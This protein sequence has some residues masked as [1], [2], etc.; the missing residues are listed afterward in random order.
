M[1]NDVCVPEEFECAEDM[2]PFAWIKIAKRL[3]ISPDKELDW[4]GGGVYANAYDIGDGRVIKISSDESD[5][6]LA[7]YL[8][9]KSLFGFVRLYDVFEIDGHRCT[10]SEKMYRVDRHWEKFMKLTDDI[11]DPVKN[12]LWWE[13]KADPALREEYGVQ[14][15][16]LELVAEICLDHNIAFSDLHWENI[17]QDSMGCVAITDL[18]CSYE[19]WSKN[20]SEDS[21][22]GGCD[23]TLCRG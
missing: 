7:Q 20:R 2:T 15:G 5:Y 19:G 3:G 17:M 4:L 16:W 8:Y 12:F 9:G 1:N 18:G 21:W 6:R 10:V 14:I 11:R 13:D 23:C 22:D